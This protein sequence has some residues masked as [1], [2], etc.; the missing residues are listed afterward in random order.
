[1]AS[2]TDI[3]TVLQNGVQGINR[4]TQQIAATFPQATAVSTSVTVGTIVFN[5][6]QAVG[7]LSVTTSSGAA[8]KVAL[9]DE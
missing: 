6:S 1:M 9:Y 7:F 3:L 2:L 4:L 8:Y 5:S